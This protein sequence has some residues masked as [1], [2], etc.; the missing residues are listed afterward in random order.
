[1][2]AT[3]REGTLGTD[4]ASCHVL[5]IELRDDEPPPAPDELRAAVETVCDKLNEAG[6]DVAITKSNA[7]V[8]EIAEAARMPWAAGVAT[9]AIGRDLEYPRAAVFMP[10]GTAG[11]AACLGYGD[12]EHYRGQSFPY[13]AGPKTLA[14]WESGRTRPS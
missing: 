3:M 4:H 8:L 14:A 12:M 10:A 5:Q 9:A 11:E 6:S 1:M 13:A 2:Q 7:V